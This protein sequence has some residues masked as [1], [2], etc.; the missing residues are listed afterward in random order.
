MAQQRVIYSIITYSRVDK[1]ELKTSVAS[2]K[3]LINYS[4]LCLRDNTNL[5]THSS[6]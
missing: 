6:V 5:L 3:N 1:G 4:K 2:L